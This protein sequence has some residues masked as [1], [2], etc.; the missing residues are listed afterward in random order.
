MT[1]DLILGT[2]GHIDHGKT[3]LVGALTG[4][5]TD[6]LP[7]EKRRG[8]TIELGFAELLLDPYRLG[9]VDVP[10]HERFVRNMLAGATG[11][12]LALLVVS[13][14]DSIKPQTREHLDILRLLNLEAG[15]IA[16]TKCDLVEPDWLALVEEEIRELVADTFLADAPIIRTSVVSG[17]GIEGLRQHLRQ[18]AERVARSRRVDRLTAPFRM[19]VDRCFTIAGHGTVVTGSVSNGSAQVGDELSI[20][21][22][23]RMVRVRSLQNH[24]RSV[25]RVERGQRAAINLVGVRHDE[26]DRGQELASPGHLVPSRLLTVRLSLIDQLSRPLK[27]RTRVRVHLGTAELLAT[28]LLLDRDEAVPGESVPAQL[29][30]SQPAVAIWAQPLVVRTESPVSTI[31]GGLVLNPHAERLRKPDAEMLGMVEDLGA[32]DPVRRASAA[33]FFAGL[34]GWHPEDLAR[35]AGID[36]PETVAASLRD[37]GQLCEICP[38]ATRTIRIHQRVLQ[39]LGDRMEALLRRMH[40]QNPLRS[41]L[42]RHQVAAAFRYLPDRALFDAIIDDLRR[43]GRVRVTGRGLAVTGEGPK[44]SA[45]ERKLLAELIALYRGAGI[46]S[47]T[48]DQCCKQV[49]RNQQSVPQLIA[50]AAADGDLVEIAGNYYL[51]A[52]VDAQLKEMLRQQLADGCGLT[53]S[54]IRELLG[55][56]RKYAVPYCEYLD[57]TRFTRREGDMRYL[58]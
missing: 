12:D 23:G 30:L 6:R 34:R 24:D 11:M 19:A 28:L 56:T 41:M 43:S 29:F 55:T 49:A 46:E 39:R 14:D 21:P 25:E 50:L 57:R 20:Q 10:G 38:S 35:T 33:L 17:E 42:D 48:V 13:A 32:S 54:Q 2:A 7:E 8:I 47:P 45:N 44:L 40:Q 27:H 36:E 58:A 3:S 4:V 18:A 37:S 52:E 26:I 9:I 22:M 5:D 1:I 31:G 16:L 51:H 15:V 53:L